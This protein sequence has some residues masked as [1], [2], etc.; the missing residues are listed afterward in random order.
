MVGRNDNLREWRHNPR[1][2][3]IT[4]TNGADR[5]KKLALHERIQHRA[6]TVLIGEF[7]KHHEIF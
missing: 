2:A 7:L 1:E 6:V 4:S 3:Q 5:D